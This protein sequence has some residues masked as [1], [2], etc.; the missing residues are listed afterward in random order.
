MGPTE[1]DIRS[2]AAILAD[3]FHPQKIIFFGSRAYG[4]PRPDS[5]TDLLIILPFDATTHRM[6]AN[7]L[8]AIRPRFGYHLV[9]RTPEAVRLW[10]DSG[11]PMMRE[12]ID[13]GI[14]LYEAAA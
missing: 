10:Y 6:T 12:A 13:R 2:V 1:E 4:T 11:D 5:D 14:L 9:P 7:M 8:G 3:K